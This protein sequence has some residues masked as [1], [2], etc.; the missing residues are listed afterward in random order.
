[1]DP[2]PIGGE[3]VIDV[4]LSQFLVGDLR[5]CT[6]EAGERFHALL[7][8]RAALPG[9][10]AELAQIRAEVAKKRKERLFAE[11]NVPPRFAHMTFRGYV[12]AA[13]NEPGK[14]AAIRAILAHFRGENEKPGI[15]LCG[16]TG[17]GKTGALSPLFL[18]YMDQGY[19]G[20]WL[21]YFDMMSNFRNWDSGNV[22]EQV[23]LAQVVNYLFI[24]DMG[25]PKRREVTDY[26]REVVFRVIDHRNNHGLPIF[27]TSNLSID[28]LADYYRPELVKRLREAC[29]IVPVTG[30]R[31]GETQ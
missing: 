31:L 6:C 1:M 14:Q 18:H 16:P 17:Q 24:D 4:R 30:A 10:E 28:R 22:H 29:V 5:F 25:D 9:Q 20:L 21:P 23:E 26:E 3:Y 8:K 13:G 2:P 19:P 27:I 15:M 12:D 11:A 7:A